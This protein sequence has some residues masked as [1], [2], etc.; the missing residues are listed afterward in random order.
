MSVIVGEKVE[1]RK[2]FG[3][4]F[5]FSIPE[6]QRPYS[7]KKEH[8]EQLF[9]DIYGANRE[10]DYFL[11]TII[12]Q[13]LESIGN[14]TKYSVID[15]QQRITTLQI[16]L[17]CLRDNVENT[18]FKDATQQKIFQKE[19]E[20]DSIPEKARIEVKDSIF[21]NKIIQTEGGTVN[22]ENIDIENDAQQNMIN[23]IEVFNEKLS[24]LNENKIKDLIKY[25]S[26]RC[27]VIYISTE[28][29]GDAFRLF[30]I[31]ND[32][33]LQLRRVDILKASNL[34]PVVMNK[35][36]ISF[37]S[38]LWEEI[39]EDLGGDNFEKLISYIRTIEVK[40][41]AKDDI[42]KEYDNLIFAKNKILRGKDFIEYLDAYRK[43]YE[44]TIL[45]R[46]ILE[47][48]NQNIEFKN[49]IY[50]MKEYLP[51]T[52][53]I[54][55]VLYYYNKFRDEGFFEFIKALEEKYTAD[56]ILGATIT[57]RVVNMNAVLRKIQEA[58]NVD[59]IIKST[60]MSYDKEAFKKK[61]NS[62]MYGQTYCKYLLLKLEYLESGRTVEKKYGTISVEH[63]VPQNFEGDSSWA[64]VFDKKQHEL[65]KNKIANLILLSKRK[66]STASNYDFEKKKEKYFKTK[67]NDLARSSK[68]FSYKKWNSEILKKRQEEIINEIL[69][70]KIK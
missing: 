35:N 5:F 70:N 33:G 30:T 63:V 7:W 11:G 49:L 68:I 10:D 64:K 28:D 61:L 50:L 1:I 59:D 51:S 62:D 23:A 56:W 48:K 22:L 34:S 3:D 14:S 69:E 57:K 39:E 47:G 31:V 44:N 19:N 38:R 12:L 60:E 26:S 55:P 45:D 8:C 24:Q 53:W 18:S 4:E 13:Q 15:G 54:P 17:A 32:R 43:I 21:F 27:I 2:F 40:D 66:N 46:N 52:D 16:L 36:D 42:L 20:A 41:K 25:I 67:T 9:D 37:Y 58:K 6:Y 65:W 29:F